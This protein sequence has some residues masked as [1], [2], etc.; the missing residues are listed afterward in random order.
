MIERRQFLQGVF[1]GVTAAGLVVAAPKHIVEAF[2]VPMGSPLSIVEP[3]FACAVMPGDQLYNAQG[4]V[5]AI[6]DAVN[7]HRDKIDVTTHNDTYKKFIM[8]SLN[9][10]IRARGLLYDEW[11]KIVSC[12][13]CGTPQPFSRPCVQCGAGPN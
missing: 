7:T 13:Y 12:Q 4:Q 1:G 10:D 6:V 8:G 11:G 9:I 3:T 5:V 2:H